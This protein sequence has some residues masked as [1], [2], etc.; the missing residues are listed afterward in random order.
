M[1]REL[2]DPESASPSRPGFSE[3]PVPRERGL[4]CNRTLN[5]RSIR[6]VGYDMDYTLV[7]YHIAAWEECAYEHTKSNLVSM[8]LPVHD[9]RFDATGIIRGLII[10]TKLGNVVKA[11]R[12]GYVKRAFHGTRPLEFDE[13]RKTYAREI[14]DL[15]ERRWVFLN[16][17]FSLSEA[18]MYSQLVDLCD[19]GK[20]PGVHSY[21][22]LYDLTRKN[23]DLSHMEGKLKA[24][25][26]NHPEKFVALD[27]DAALA[28]LDQKHAGKVLMLITN[29]EWEFT[30]AMMGYSYDRFLPKGM[31][32]RDL[33]DIVIVGAQKPAF[34]SAR[35]VM[36]EIASED[37]LL[38]PL[39]GPLQRGKSYFGGNAQAVESYLGLSGDE[40]LYVGDH[41]FGDVHVTK[42]ILRWRTAL[43][44][45]EIE[46][47]IASSHVADAELKKLDEG[48]REKEEL[49]RAHSVLR[50]ELSRLRAGYGPKPSRS[51]AQITEELARLR[52]AL[53]AL[54]D[55]V[56][57]LAR[58]ASEIS[59]K[60][61]G[62]LMWAGNDKSHF[63][64]QVERYADVY[65]SRVSNF[66]FATPF[67][68][69]RSP[70]G[71]LPHDHAPNPVPAAETAPDAAGYPFRR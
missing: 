70:R 25:I 11:N 8:G 2:N 17:L 49:E 21:L 34:F 59:N 1:N 69:L 31:T 6:A 44:V 33:F 20:L 45:R 13:L 43:I 37:G 51:E 14:V 62:P 66:A 65:T 4:F 30:K 50:L 48:M 56:A 55:K 36:F 16:T 41:I 67:V 29:S 52:S 24:E 26:S 22:D 64:R 53:Q 32:W 68:Y 63:A 7:H 61:W 46:E 9:L 58:K 47:E 60:N 18:C 12:F 42:Q 54:D 3:G 39:A 28:L 19:A 71:S 35:P 10:D 40:I 27:P 5:M 23:V 15:S 57:P 38:R